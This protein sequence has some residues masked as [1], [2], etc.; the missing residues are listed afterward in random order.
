MR[1]LWACKGFSQSSGTCSSINSGFYK[2]N[3]ILPSRNQLL[4]VAPFWS[5][6]IIEIKEIS[7]LVCWEVLAL[8]GSKS[9]ALE[10]KFIYKNTCF[11]IL[12][13]RFRCNFQYLQFIEIHSLGSYQLKKEA[14][15]ESN[16]VLFGSLLKRKGKNLREGLFLFFN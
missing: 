4:K 5:I 3:Q 16:F 1:L 12:T 10:S 13:C 9:F 6:F 2:L 15:Q 7:E 14:V 8:A 11:S